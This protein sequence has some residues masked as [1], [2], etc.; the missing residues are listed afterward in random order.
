LSPQGQTTLS[1][2]FGLLDKCA[3]GHIR[4]KGKR[5]HKWTIYYQGKTFWELPKGDH[6]SKEQVQL[7]KVAK[8]VRSLEISA[9][10]AVK[11]IPALEGMSLGEDQQPEAPRQE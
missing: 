11:A 1:E 8:M 3:P 6:D 4:S 2:V 9:S 10:C 5:S 7:F